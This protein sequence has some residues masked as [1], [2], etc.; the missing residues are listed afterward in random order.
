MDTRKIGGFLK[1][2]RKEKGL[3]QEQ[4]AELLLV[5]GKT[6]SRW[7]TG[8]NM[9][10]L[11]LLIQIAEFY[12]VEVQE[13]LDGERKEGSAT[14]EFKETLDKIAD[15]GR[16]KKEQAV[17][18]GQT[19]F[20]ITF[21]VCAAAIVVQIMVGEGF[22]AVLG[23]T[24][25]LFAGGVSY[26]A[27]MLYHGLGE[28]DSP[29]KETMIGIL[30]SGGMTVA[31]IVRAVR[32]GMTPSQIVRS[33]ILFFTGIMLLGSALMRGMAFVLRKRKHQR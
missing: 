6:V 19:A 28:P 15:Y 30:C 12:G 14:P 21:A 16:L 1:A 24:A 29:A 3:T 32:L 20:V 8:T 25:A 18:V 4:L 22:P 26:I 2:L 27:M 9:P 13:I 23:E 17:K 7:E 31:L 10:D 11:S 5:S 33:A